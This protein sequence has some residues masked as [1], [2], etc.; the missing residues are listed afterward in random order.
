MGRYARPVASAAWVPGRTTASLP[1]ARTATV[2]CG[3]QIRPITYPCVWIL[4][5]LPSILDQ[6][7]KEPVLDSA[8]G[9]G[10]GVCS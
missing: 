1:A 5:F 7:S 2:T 4:S 9:D 8:I 3:Q 6:G 10:K